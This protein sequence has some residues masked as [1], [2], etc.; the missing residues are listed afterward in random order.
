M[1]ADDGRIA[2]ESRRTSKI[3]KGR[4]LFP[5]WEQEWV[6]PKKQRP[7]LD[8]QAGRRRPRRRLEMGTVALGRGLQPAD[9]ARQEQVEAKGKPE[10]VQPAERD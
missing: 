2:D 6:I 1:V 9:A 8:R 3:E 5:K 4:Y 7:R 10:I